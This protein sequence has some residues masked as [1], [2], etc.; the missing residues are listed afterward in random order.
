MS[1]PTLPTEV[2][3]A[4][5]V[6]P[7]NFLALGDSYTIGEGIS[8]NDCWPRQLVKQLGKEQIVVAEPTI[9]AQ[10]GW[11]TEELD[12]AI[13]ES[14]LNP[15]Y[16]LV[17]LLI[18][19]NDQY[20]KYPIEHYAPRFTTLLERAIGFAGGR[21]DR[22]I[23]ISIPDWSVTPFAAKDSSSAIRERISREI[24]AYNS[25]NLK[26]ANKYNISYVDITP[27][28]R[29]KGAQSEFLTSDDL[30]PSAAMY[31]DWVQLLLPVVRQALTG[32]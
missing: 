30:H 10:T 19:V 29:R 11:T 22:V 17:T 1:Q 8:I 21:K 16:Q 31:R 27:I 26:I 20:R 18:G 2:L 5:L 15:P 14:V 12:Q 32:S 23:V 28:T 4:T 13:N 25:V 6:V 3:N 7:L 24:D 9:I